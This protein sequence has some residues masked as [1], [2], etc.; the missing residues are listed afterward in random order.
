MEQQLDWDLSWTRELVIVSKKTNKKLIVCPEGIFFDVDGELCE[1]TLDDIHHIWMFEPK[2]F[3]E[4]YI[5]FYGSD[6]EFLQND[7]GF[8]AVIDVT[9]KFKDEFYL[10][11]S[12]LKDNGFDINCG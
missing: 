2:L 11:Y 5:S 6:D 9:R 1:V 10:I 3:K 4:G 12:V 8:S 7:D